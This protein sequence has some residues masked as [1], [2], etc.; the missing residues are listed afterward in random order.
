M[1]IEPQHLLLSQRNTFAYEN[2]WTLST[3]KTEKG[4][5]T[6]DDKQGLFNAFPWDTVLFSKDL[7]L[8]TPDLRTTV[9]GRDIPL[10][11]ED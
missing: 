7:D 3:Y 6:A 1:L 4:V 11:S 8:L 9:R 2:V 5:A 10:S